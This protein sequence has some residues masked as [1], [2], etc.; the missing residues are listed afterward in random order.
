M[1]SSTK[2]L[3]LFTCKTEQCKHKYSWAASA[4]KWLAM[5]I[6]LG[7]GVKSIVHILLGL[8]R[9][10]MGQAIQNILSRDTAG[11][12]I[13]IGAMPTIYKLIL[14]L[15]RHFGMKQ[16]KANSIVAG[17]LCAA[18]LAFDSDEGRR[19]MFA[20][21]W[22]ARVFEVL[23][24]LLENNK[25]VK[26]PKNWGVIAYCWMSSF[27]TRAMYFEPD[28]CPGSVYKWI[29]KIGGMKFNDLELLYVCQQKGVKI[30]GP[31]PIPQ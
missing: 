4:A 7:V 11:F 30:F 8:I 15:L 26:V 19:K 25:V 10:N 20:Y 3:D 1:S 6:A 13:F 9:K 5:N 28:V 27:F 2:I 17:L 23:L 31:S 24:N 18:A 14:W 22:A 12:C 21:Y 16:D 29:K